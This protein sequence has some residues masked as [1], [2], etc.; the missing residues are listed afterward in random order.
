MDAWLW[1]GAIAIAVAVVAS[2]AAVFRRRGR[3]DRERLAEARRLGFDRPKGQY[4]HID[5][6]LCIG[7]G[8]CVA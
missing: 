2:Y 5:T 6:A 7:C 4:P 1:A 8:A 3:I